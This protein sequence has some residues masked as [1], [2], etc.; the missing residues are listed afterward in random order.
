MA[1]AATTWWMRRRAA[2]AGWLYRRSPLRRRLPL[3]SAVFVLRIPLYGIP[4][5]VAYAAAYLLFP[6]LMP[7]FGSLASAV[8][9]IA[10]GLLV[11]L[12]VASSSFDA[13]IFVFMTLW[14]LG[15][16]AEWP[17]RITASGWLR[18]YE[19]VRT[20]F[21]LIGA[22]II[23]LSIVGEELTFRGVLLPLVAHVG[24]A[25]VAV[26]V[27][28][29]AFVAMQF[30]GMPTRMDAAPPAMSAVFM[31]L[32]NCLLVLRTGE[33]L[34]PCVVHLTFFAVLTN[35]A[36]FGRWLQRKAIAAAAQETPA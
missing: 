35:Y 26:L 2:I 10:G 1:V 27:S 12:G 22:P 21:P 9:A 19:V 36:S 33:L 13:I 25:V 32:V 20:T 6:D 30:L 4:G 24:G 29:A 17:P 8:P 7:T 14:R 11:G 16:S 15:L 23:V 3:H 18:G 28:T 31:G 34:G 5:L